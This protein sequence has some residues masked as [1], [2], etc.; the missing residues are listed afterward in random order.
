LRATPSD[1]VN[2]IIVVDNEFND[3]QVK[4]DGKNVKIT[5]GSQYQ[6]KL[7]GLCGD[8][9][10]ETEQEFQ[11]PDMCVYEDAE[12]F[13]Q[14]YALAGQHCAQSPVPKGQKRCPQKNSQES[15]ESQESGIVEKKETKTVIGPNGQSTIVRQQ[16]QQQLNQQQRSEVI[17]S[18]SNAEEL[19]RQQQQQVE[20]QMA[21]QE[22]QPLSQSQQQA[23]YGATPQQQK[24]IQRLRTQY[25]QRDD[26]ICFT[27]KPVLAC[28]QGQAT[29]LKQ[30][31]V[32]FHCLPKTSPFTQQLIVESEKQVIKQLVN[33]RV[34]L[35]QQIDVPVACV[36]A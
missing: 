1:A 15:Q 3:L 31:K 4:Y 26:M 27:T 6:G 21:R 23:L 10:D 22:G 24:L 32:D 28:V 14:S 20:N 18:Q 9:N 12:D 2:P 35:R 7:C 16:I 36:A 34:D 33:K 13:A 5:V 25:I 19:K 11:G 29:A 30:V 8:N 17:E